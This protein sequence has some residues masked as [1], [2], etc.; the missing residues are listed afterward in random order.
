MKETLF[1]VALLFLLD[2]A[3]IRPSTIENKIKDVFVSYVGRV[4]EIKVDVELASFPRDLLGRIDKA[5]VRMRGFETETLPISITPK[6]VLAG[7]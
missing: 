7:K 6:K 1:Y 2:K 3:L 4:E 5:E